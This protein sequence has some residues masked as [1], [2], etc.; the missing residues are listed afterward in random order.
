MATKQERAARCD[1]L[2]ALIKRENNMTTV[3]SVAH[4]VYN[5]MVADLVVPLPDVMAVLDTIRSRR[6][7][8]YD[9]L[10]NLYPKLGGAQVMQ[11]VRYATRHHLI[12][13]YVVGP[14]MLIEWMRD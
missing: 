4:L 2:V 14:T 10:V 8:E 5:S 12:R 7:M 9:G 6:T 3:N 11:V 1:A 13:S